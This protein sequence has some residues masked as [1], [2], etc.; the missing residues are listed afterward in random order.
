MAKKIKLTHRFVPVLV[1]LVYM[2]TLIYVRTEKDKK[3]IDK[4]WTL[5]YIYLIFYIKWGIRKGKWLYIFFAVPINIFSTTFILLYKVYNR[6]CLV[7]PDVFIKQFLFVLAVNVLPLFHY[8]VTQVTSFY[9][10]LDYIGIIQLLYDFIVSYGLH[11]AAT[12][13]P[14]HS[15]KF[16][17]LP[18]SILL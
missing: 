16:V 13:Y 12:Q 15:T 8:M 5:C 6:H 2:F 14:G 17:M 4:D 9:C 7:V 18:S 11:H 3:G 10:Q 1:I